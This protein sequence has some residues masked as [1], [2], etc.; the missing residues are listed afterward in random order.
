[1]PIV[2]Y[3]VNL[4]GSEWGRAFDRLSDIPDRPRILLAATRI[5]EDLWRSVLQRQGYDT[6]ERSAGSAEYM[7]AFHFAWLSLQP[8]E[9]A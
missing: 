4:P 8:R 3:D 9:S 1:M 5:D 2:V 6:V 7:R